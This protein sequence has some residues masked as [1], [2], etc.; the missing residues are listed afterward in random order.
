MGI[1]EDISA[2]LGIKETKYLVLA[3]GGAVALAGVIALTSQGAQ[4]A[5]P[6]PKANGQA[7]SVDSKEG[8]L[9]AL[10]EMKSKQEQMREQMKQ[11]ASEVQSKSLSLSQVCKRC[12]EMQ[13]TNPLDKYS[14]S[15]LEF[16]KTLAQYEEDAAVQSAIAALMGAPPGGAAAVTEASSSLTPKK[17]LDIHKFMLSEYEKLAGADKASK[18]ATVLSFAAQAYVAGK[19][20]AQFKIASKDIEDAMLTHEGALTSDPEFAAVNKKLQQAIAK[21]LG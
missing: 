16:N 18:D 7:G 21:L 15:S 2:K 14:V 10:Q 20:E 13:V 5:K 4:T 19:T 12:A 8:V 17:L 11:L 6:S 3:A 1:L 9:Q